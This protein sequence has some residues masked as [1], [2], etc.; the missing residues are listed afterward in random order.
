MSRGASRT[1]TEEDEMSDDNRSNPYCANCGDERGGPYGH[2]TS[3]CHW[4]DPCTGCDCA[5]LASSVCLRRA[6]ENIAA[7]FEATRD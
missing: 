2:E 5:Q 1:P 3:E 4:N 7:K 6:A